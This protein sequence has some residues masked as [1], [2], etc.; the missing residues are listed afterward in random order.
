MAAAAQQRRRRISKRVGEEEEE[1]E[2]ENPVTC[3]FLGP[4]DSWGIVRGVL[5]NKGL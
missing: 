2:D 4:S 1:E 5:E 3:H